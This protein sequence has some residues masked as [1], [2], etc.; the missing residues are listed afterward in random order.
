MKKIIAG[1]FTIIIIASAPV[2]SQVIIGL[3]FGEKLN[4]GNIEFGLNGI[5]NYSN[6]DGLDNGGS[7]RSK[8]GF[9]LYLDYKI[10]D[11]FIL[12]TSFFFA[13]P[14]GQVNFNATDPFFTTPDS[15]LF[16]PADLTT[17]R[18]LNYFELP[19][20]L[21]YRPMPNVGLGFGGYI[22]VLT[23]AQD[24][25]ANT[26]NDIDASYVVDIRDDMN[27]LDYGLMGSV[28]F[29]FNGDPGSQIRL[30]YM[31]GL[32]EL[33]KEPYAAAYNETFQLAVLIP[34]KFGVLP[35]KDDTEKD[36]KAE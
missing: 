26:F 10:S 30:S 18:V 2:K 24:Y 1:L 32:N 35:A 15:T 29:H 14:K 33:F 9:G 20:M 12:A 7:P 4:N 13:S 23:K 19:I 25:Y 16:P 34:I 31:L 22:S 21:E 36:V 28:H 27:R 17:E 11:K 5:I 3:L 8:F 6:I